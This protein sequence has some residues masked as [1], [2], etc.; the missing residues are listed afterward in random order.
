MLTREIQE[1]RERLQ[2]K[3]TPKRSPITKSQSSLTTSQVH[4]DPSYNWGHRGSTG[5]P[6]EADGRRPRL[7]SPESFGSVS[8][9]QSRS[10]DAPFVRSASADVRVIDQPTT[11]SDTCTK[12]TYNRTL[13]TDK[14]ETAPSNRHVFDTTPDIP[15]IPVIPVTVPGPMTHADGLTGTKEETVYLNPLI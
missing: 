9:L 5:G 12:T 10:E 6:P 2:N 8:A 13:G 4:D 11:S 14:V 15:V 1:T 3:M 7:K